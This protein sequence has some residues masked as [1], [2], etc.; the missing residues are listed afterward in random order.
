[1]TGTWEDNF[2]LETIPDP[3]NPGATLPRRWNPKPD[4]WAKLVSTLEQANSAAATP[5]VNFSQTDAVVFVVRTANNPFVAN[6]PTGTSIGRFVWP[7]QS[8]QGVTL[9]ALGEGEKL[10]GMERIE[11]KDL[12]NGNGGNGGHGGNGGNGDA[13]EEA[14]PPEE[15]GPTVH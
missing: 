12:A 10:A 8:T 9:I 15:P 7:Q 11:E 3:A 13:H 5:V 1:M 4:T 2:D 6:P 14:P